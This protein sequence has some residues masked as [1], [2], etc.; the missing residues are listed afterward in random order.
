MLKSLLAACAPLLLW[1]LHFTVCYGAAAVRYDGA[2]PRL[3]L[4]AFTV[5]AAGGEAWLLWRA[6][7]RARRAGARLRDRAMA[8][9]ALLA[10]PA[11]LWTGLPLLLL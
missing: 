1:A 9:G 2:A 7:P 8:A 4:I 11:V 6:W 10:L 3:P 5:L